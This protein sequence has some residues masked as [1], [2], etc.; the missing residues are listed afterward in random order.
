MTHK[1]AASRYRVLIGDR[2]GRPVPCAS[3]V[4]HRWRTSLNQRLSLGPPPLPAGSMPRGLDT[5]ADV[6][7]PRQ[8]P[9]RRAKGW[10]GL[11]ASDHIADVRRAR[12]RTG[13]NCER[14]CGNGCTPCGCCAAGN[15]G[16]VRWQPSSAW[17]TGRCSGGW[18]CTEMAV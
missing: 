4:T 10:P 11:A 8:R 16:W 15:A 17:T 13:Q 14:M 2:C 6:W 3:W 9:A 5:A 18:H 1:L 12:G 7:W